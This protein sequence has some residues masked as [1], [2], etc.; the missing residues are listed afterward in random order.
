MKIKMLLTIDDH[1]PDEIIGLT[2]F[3]DKIIIATRVRLLMLDHDE[4]TEIKIKEL[5][6][7]H[8]DDLWPNI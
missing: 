2:P 4:E 3:R 8:R 1:E 7:R 6:R 5:L